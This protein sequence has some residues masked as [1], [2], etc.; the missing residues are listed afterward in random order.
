MKTKSHIQT[1]ST[2]DITEIWENYRNNLL[3]FILSK[4]DDE[5]LA[6]DILQ[7]VFLKLMLAK[8][9][10]KEIHNLQSWLYQ[11]S[12]N[13]ISDHYRKYYKDRPKEE[14]SLDKNQDAGLNGC[15]CD[16]TGFVIQRYLPEEYA[17]PLFMSDIE[18]MPQKEIAA[19]LGLSL[20]GAKSRIQRGRK[21]LKALILKCVD[22]SLNQKGQISEFQLKES[23]ELPAELRQELENKN[24]SF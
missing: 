10:E 21:M 17:H 9:K 19:K 15:I 5:A 3:Q 1:L 23:C 6:N 8:K 14:L 24:I 2:G 16:I 13:T 7:D 18:N 11:V 22:V 4:T 12:R 20:S